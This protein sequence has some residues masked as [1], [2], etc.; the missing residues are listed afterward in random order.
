MDGRRSA[1][2][3]CRARLISQARLISRAPLAVDSGALSGVDLGAVSDAPLRK[4]NKPRPRRVV[5]NV[6]H[7]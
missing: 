6:G 4:Q 2:Y 7:P 3:G 1:K 5:L